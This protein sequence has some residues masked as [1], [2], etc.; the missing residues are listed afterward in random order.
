MNLPS[1]RVFC[2]HHFCYDKRSGVGVRQVKSYR[3]RKELTYNKI[4]GRRYFKAEGEAA[5]FSI[6]QLRL[7]FICNWNW[8]SAASV[9]MSEEE[10]NSL[11]SEVNSWQL[12]GPHTGS[13]IREGGLTLM[14]MNYGERNHVCGGPWVRD[15]IACRA[16]CS[17][18]ASRLLGLQPQPALCVSGR[19]HEF[20]SLPENARGGKMLFVQRW[21]Q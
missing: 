13:N 14:L 5:Q 16:V 15:S 19:L 21:C 7:H 18:L 2:Q 6:W 11:R 12:T 10:T 17:N 20:V 9:N 1:S 4:Q 3:R 8:C